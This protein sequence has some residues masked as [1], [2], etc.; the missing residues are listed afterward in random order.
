[1]R[2]L[3]LLE[4]YHDNNYDADD[5]NYDDD[6][7]GMMMIM[8]INLFGYI[9]GTLPTAVDSQNLLSGHGILY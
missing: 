3:G 7:G 8:M 5:D 9:P 4:P 2:C 1:M 6:N